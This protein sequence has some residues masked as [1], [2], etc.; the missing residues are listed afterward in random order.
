MMKLIENV[1][2]QS[3]RFMR[4]VIVKNELFKYLMSR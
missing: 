4:D 1:Y 2:V 3:G